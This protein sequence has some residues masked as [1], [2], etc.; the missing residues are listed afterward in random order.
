MLWYAKFIRVGGN[1][2]MAEIITFPSKENFS[3]KSKLI[4]ALLNI[5][6][7]LMIKKKTS[8]FI[9]KSEL[10]KILDDTKTSAGNFEVAKAIDDVFREYFEPKQEMVDTKTSLFTYPTESQNNLV[11]D[12]TGHD[13]EKGKAF[14]KA[15]GYHR[16]GILDT[17]QDQ[18]VN[19]A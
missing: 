4:D 7:T 12:E 8:D 1:F 13:N 5:R 16:S 9:K 18:G 3:F 15:D 17:S 11:D 14:V 2:N 10:R 6:L 19:V